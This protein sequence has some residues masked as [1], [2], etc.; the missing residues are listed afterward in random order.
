MHDIGLA[1]I[2]LPARNLDVSVAFYNKYVP[3]LLLEHRDFIYRQ[4]LELPI[5]F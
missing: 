2:A 3:P 1:P 5:V 4:Y